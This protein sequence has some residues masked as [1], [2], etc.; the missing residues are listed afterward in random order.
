VYKILQHWHH[1]SILTPN[2]RYMVS[3]FSKEV[4]GIMNSSLSF[5]IFT[6]V[7]ICAETADKWENHKSTNQLHDDPTLVHL[8]LKLWNNDKSWFFTLFPSHSIA[9]FIYASLV[10]WEG[11][12][13]NCFTWKNKMRI[14]YQH[15]YRIPAMAWVH[16]A[17][18]MPLWTT[19]S[20]ANTPILVRTLCRITNKM[21]I[22][23]Y[24]GELSKHVSTIWDQNVH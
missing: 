15:L 16:P 6:Q 10:I 20:K 9:P 23:P 17:Q 3:Q 14:P 7:V 2:S 19:E 1:L 4:T 21:W 18:T 24:L 22:S 12:R 13:S 8:R 5:T 11:K